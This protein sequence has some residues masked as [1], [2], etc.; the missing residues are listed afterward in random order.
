MKILTTEQVEAYR[1]EGATH[2][3]RVMGAERAAGYLAKLEAGER[4]HG[5]A[6]KKVLRTKAHLTLEWVDE[7]VHD[8]TILNAVEDVIGPD[9][10]L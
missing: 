1:E 4:E 8:D 2:P 7:L 9:I 3:I 6:F 5:E 10:R